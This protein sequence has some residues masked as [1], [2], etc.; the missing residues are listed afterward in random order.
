MPDQRD[1][2][3]ESDRDQLQVINIITINIY[4]DGDQICAIIGEMPNEIAIG[5]GASSIDAL[6][7]LISDLDRDNIC[8]MC[9]SDDPFVTENFYGD[10][11]MKFYECRECDH[12]WEIKEE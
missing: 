10:Y 4:P 3:F 6:K 11:S 8:D 1:Y 5:F 9:L 2:R 12:G 7:Q